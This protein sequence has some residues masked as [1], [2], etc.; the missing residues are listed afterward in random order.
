M[1]TTYN[2]GSENLENVKNDKNED[3]IILKLFR[4]KIDPRRLDRNFVEAFNSSTA[5]QNI[6]CK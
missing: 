3:E 5:F 6:G 4:K 1:T 2:C